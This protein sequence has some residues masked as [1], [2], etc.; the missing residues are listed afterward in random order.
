MDIVNKDIEKDPLGSPNEG[1]VEIQ[2]K[3]GDLAPD[4][5]LFNEN[6]RL[7]RLSDYRGKMVA[8]YFYPMDETPGCVQEAL[9]LRDVWDGFERR[10]VA[11][12]GVSVDDVASHFSFK[13]H[14][15]LPFPLLSDSDHLVSENY[16]VWDGEFARRVT[17]LISSEG[18]VLKIWP[19]V[20]PT[21]HA[22]ELILELDKHLAM[23]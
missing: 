7:V 5:E 13:E 6:G 15:E 3:T 14:Y 17:F 12:L 21:S 11:V 9:A 18:R 4:F 10:G 16:G 22:K 1:K 2:I 20:D 8:L 23:V 19:R